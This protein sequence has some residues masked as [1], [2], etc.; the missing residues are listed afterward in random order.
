MST[1][2]VQRIAERR[3]VFGPVADA[4]PALELPGPVAL[5]GSPRSLAAVRDDAF[6]GAAVYRFDGVRLHNPRSGVDA[7]GALVDAQRCASVVAIGSSSAMD[8]GKAVA[9]LIVAI[10]LVPQFAQSAEVD[11]L[12]ELL[13]LL[14]PITA[15]KDSKLQKLILQIEPDHRIERSERLIE[16]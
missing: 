12:R 7:A 10:A 8:L 3:V 5:I 15:A 14:A 2:A 9:F 13:A 4:L 1:P 6:G 16:Q 11:V